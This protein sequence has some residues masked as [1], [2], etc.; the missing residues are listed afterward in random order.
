[1]KKF[2]IGC[3]IAATTLTAASCA[4]K[5]A[6]STETVSAEQA[7][8][9]P[10]PME[11]G[12]YV[13]DSYDITGKNARSGR[14]DG[15]LLVSLSPEQS[16]LYVYENGN[17][18]KIDYKIILKTQFEKGDSGMY[19]ASDSKGNPVMLRTDSTVYTL[20]FDKNESQIRINFDKNPKSTGSATAILERIT[21][22]IQ[23]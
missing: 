19:V 16:A 21:K 9:A 17:R 2:M 12:E 22:M 7:E 3:M 4:S 6:S 18:A 11:C 8:A 15:R 20:A 1:M 13:A 5:D 10:Q 14:F 23:K